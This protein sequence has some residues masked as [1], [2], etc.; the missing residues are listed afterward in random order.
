[1][2]AVLHHHIKC[3]LPET[4]NKNKSG[5]KREEQKQLVKSRTEAGA[6]DQSRSAANQTVGALIPDC[7]SLHTKW[8]RHEPQVVL[9]SEF[10]C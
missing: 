2:V 5:L 1:M 8:A 9:P 6:Q 3:C 7:S 10:E 4:T